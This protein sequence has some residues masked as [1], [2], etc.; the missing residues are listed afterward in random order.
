MFRTQ[1]SGFRDRHRPV[2]QVRQFINQQVNKILNKTPG[3]T[4]LYKYISSKKGKRELIETFRKYF[5]DTAEPLFIVHA[6]LYGYHAYIVGD[7]ATC[8]GQ[9]LL[10]SKEEQP[11]PGCSELMADDRET[12]EILEAHCP[13]DECPDCG[14]PLTPAPLFG[15]ICLPHPPGEHYGKKFCGLPRNVNPSWFSWIHS[16]LE[17]EE[18]QSEYMLSVLKFAS[19]EQRLKVI[20]YIG[21]NRVKII[22]ALH[23]T[24]HLTEDDLLYLLD[25]GHCDISL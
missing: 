5:G 20:P 12:W 23:D 7:K 2:V 17:N 8:V 14:H 13:H 24:G 11:V 4:A 22:S 21:K 25:Q 16:P 19:H 1:K 18:S 3:G 10:F 9:G 15:F 6:E